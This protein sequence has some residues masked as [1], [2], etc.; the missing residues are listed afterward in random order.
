MGYG[1]VNEDGEGV[2]E[3]PAVPAGTD[4]PVIVKREGCVHGLGSV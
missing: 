1:S 2:N 4:N 3:C